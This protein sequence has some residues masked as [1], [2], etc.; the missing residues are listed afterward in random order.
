MCWGTLT[1][2]LGQEPSLLVA[3]Y[4]AKLESGGLSHQDNVRNSVV[5][6]NSHDG[7]F[8]LPVKKHPAFPSSTC[9][10]CTQPFFYGHTL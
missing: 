5:H 7:F 4:L 6:G 10:T 2:W 3:T 9:Q 1:S 8:V